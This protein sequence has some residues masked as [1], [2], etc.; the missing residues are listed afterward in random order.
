MILFDNFDTKFVCIIHYKY[1][2]ALVGMLW[3][4][5]LMKARVAEYFGDAASADLTTDYN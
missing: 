4:P 3:L 5:L 2:H 1:A